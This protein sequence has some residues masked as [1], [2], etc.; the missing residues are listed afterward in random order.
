[1]KY[2]TVIFINKD[3]DPYINF[4]LI[5]KL[6]KN[7]SAINYLKNSTLYVDYLQRKISKRN[8]IHYQTK[9]IY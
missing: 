2:L 6:V 5:I 3:E 4:N 7:N 1:M 8:I 9:L